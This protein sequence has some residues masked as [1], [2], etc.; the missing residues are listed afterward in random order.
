MDTP[1]TPVEGEVTTPV[2]ATPVVET[3]PETPTAPAQA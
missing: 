1:T 2:E 3:T